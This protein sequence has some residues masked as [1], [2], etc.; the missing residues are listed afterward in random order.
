MLC[1]AYLGS[2]S[3]QARQPFQMLE[4]RYARVLRDANATVP[5]SML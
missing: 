5:Y 4:E 1:Y 3:F 2:L